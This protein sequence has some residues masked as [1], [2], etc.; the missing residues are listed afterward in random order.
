MLV[1]SLKKN[2]NEEAIKGQG[3]TTLTYLFNLIH[4]SFLM[5]NLAHALTLKLMICVGK[6]GL[7]FLTHK[8]QISDNK[9]P[10]LT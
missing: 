5:E 4:D 6:D 8:Q 7:N 1:A 3:P 10:V 9:V 2:N